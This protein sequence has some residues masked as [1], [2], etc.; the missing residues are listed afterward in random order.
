MEFPYNSQKQTCMCVYI[1][2]DSLINKKLERTTFI[3]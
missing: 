3:K 1:F 2:Q